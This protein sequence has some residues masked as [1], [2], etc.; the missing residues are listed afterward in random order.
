VTEGFDIPGMDQPLWDEATERQLS[1]RELLKYAGA[2]AGALGLAALLAACGTGKSGGSSGGGGG[3]GGG[4]TEVGSTA[5][6]ADQKLHHQVNFAN[7]PYYIDT[8]H[9]KHPSLE[10]FTKK[11]GIK[12]TYSEPIQDNTSFFQKIKPA[13]QAGQPTG[14]DIV[15]LT[16]NSPVF[17]QVVQAGWAI[18]LDH[19]K[20]TNFDKYASD[21]V[22]NPS[23]DPG[24]KYSMA[25]QSGYTAIAYNTKF[26]KEDINSVQSLFDPKYKGK[27]GMMSDP[28]ELGSFG[29]LAT[30]KDPAQSTQADWQGAAKK[31]QSQKELLRSYYD[32]S[33][34]SA[35]KNEDTWIS[36]CWSGDIFQANLS[37]FKDLKLV[38]P[39]EGAMFWTDNMM[40]PKGAENPVDAMAIMDYVYQPAVQAEIEDYNNYV[41]PVPAAKPIIAKKLKDPAVANSP[42]VFPDAQMQS[43]SRTY[44]QYKS[45]DDLLAWNNLFLPIIQG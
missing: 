43:L 20:M 35:L 23:Y 31:L 27:I 45:N 37:G 22:T 26:I 13:L 25:W 34:I 40:I 44:Y 18:P 41:C 9:G 12:V 30:G 33:Y 11:T 42:T 8:S 4:A 19:S 1:R 6:W 3:G 7:W 14:Y 15:V 2:G 32:Q 5:W 24:N 36:M 21:L 29:L 10:Q 16:N 38:I 28:Q 17:S 39:Q